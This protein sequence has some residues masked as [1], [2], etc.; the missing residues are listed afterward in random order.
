MLQQAFDRETVKAVEDA[1]R[2]EPRLGAAFR[3]R[4]IG[5]ESDGV[6]VL[7]GTVERLAEKKLALLRA[8]AV[9]GVQQLIDRMHV[10]AKEPVRHVRPQVCK[11]FAQ[12]S[13]FAGF[14]IREDIAEG[15]LATEF[16]PCTTIVG[17]PAG[18]IDVEENDGVITLNGVVPSL[19]H[20]RVAGVLAWRVPGVRD[21]INGIVV[22]PAEEDGPD[23]IEEAVRVVLDREPSVD[24]A[25]IKVGVRGR[26]VR[27]TG[28]VGSMSER[29]IAE[30]DVWAVFGVDDVI[31]EIEVRR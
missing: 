8:A 16:Q 13:D 12:D 5:M 21:V 4:R 31:N 14:E 20:K 18:R 10:A 6:L 9:P 19:V 17:A 30:N 22:D 7:E 3:L 23:S 15:E 24:A 27:L 2:A 25:Q 28:L 29:E 11:L 26:V 1:F